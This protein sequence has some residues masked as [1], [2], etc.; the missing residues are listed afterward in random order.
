MI[1]ISDNFLVTLDIKQ[2]KK[3][4]QM[5]RIILSG[6]L[7][8]Q[9]FQYAAGLALMQRTKSTLQIDKQ[10]LEKKTRGTSRNYQLS[11]FTIN[12]PVKTNLI[13]KW[14]VKAYSI[15]DKPNSFISNA[16]NIFRDE[17]AQYFDIKFNSSSNN[18]IL[19]GYFQNELYFDNIDDQIRHSFTFK[20]ALKGKNEEIATL[21]E[22]SD[23]VSIHIRRGDYLNKN[24]NLNVLSIEYY[25]KA[26]ATIAQKVPNAHF[27]IFS[28]DTDWVKQNLNI[29]SNA[30]TI[31]DWNTGDDSYRDM[32]LMSLCKHNIIANSSFSWWGAWLNNN[33]SKT[34]I[35]PKTWYKAD[36][37]NNY[38]KGFIPES[39][40]II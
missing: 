34:V 5:I 20:E 28:D 18:T 24:S 22:N 12:N 26:I 30:Y 13:D 25:Q 37:P 7:G 27:F 8:N 6:G 21:I 29:G 33:P 9:M 16:F 11:I 3:I 19:F 14:I 23:S 40:T 1:I 4:N 17:K 35:A 2:V 38:P 15:L 39:W 36:K 32:Q 31:I 10:I